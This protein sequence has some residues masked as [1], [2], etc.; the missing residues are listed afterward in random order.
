MKSNAIYSFLSRNSYL[1]ILGIII[2][3]LL[4]LILTLMPAET[5]SHHKIWSYDKLGHLLL[6]GTWTLLLGL[7]HNISKAGSTNFWIIFL[8]GASFGILIELLQY[9]LPFLNRHADMGDV[10]FDI[11]GCLLAMGAL[12]II[13]PQK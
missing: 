7:Y 9:S 10:L 5:F 1:L 12:K 11:I 2:L 13:I 6:F 8:I 4:M 3:T